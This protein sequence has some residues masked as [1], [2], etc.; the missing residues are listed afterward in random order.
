MTDK[1]SVAPKERV[2][3]VYKPATGDAQEQ[4]EL[5]L[6][7]LVL[8]DFSL[9]DDDTPLEDLKPI[10]IDKDNF[11]DVL[12]GQNLSLAFSVPDLLSE[13]KKEKEEEE[14]KTDIPLTLTFTSLRDFEPD[15]LVDQVPE[16]QKLIKLREALKALKGPL[17]NVPDFRKKLQSFI[18]DDEIRHRLLQELG[19]GDKE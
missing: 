14:E 17:G 2:N 18:D 4:V 6:K 5:P 3:I 7:Q 12:R 8:G 11:N 1:G 13:K 15:S 19:I 10:R 16:L 9:R